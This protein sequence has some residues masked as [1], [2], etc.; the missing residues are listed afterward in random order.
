MIGQKTTIAKKT[1]ETEK[2]AKEIYVVAFAHA[3]HNPDTVMVM[4][5]Y[6]TF[7]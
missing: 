6:T 2:H 5:S 3:I 7:A 1:C 4:P